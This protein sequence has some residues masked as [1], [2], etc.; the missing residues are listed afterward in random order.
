MSFLL[1]QAQTTSSTKKTV[2]E[3]F[4]DTL[5]EMSASYFA[6]HRMWDDLDIPTPRVKLKADYHKL[7]VPPTYYFAPVQQAFEL[8][9][10]PSDK[11]GM[12]AVDSLN[13]VIK[14]AEPQYELPK[15]TNSVGA[16]RWV[17]EI[18]L[19]VYLN[20]PN[21]VKGNEASFADMK[22]L[23]DAHTIVTPRKENLV[24]YVMPGNEKT[25]A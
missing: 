1:V 7:I 14:S 6:Y 16:D 18:L 5:Q 23:S 17:N 8:D 22:V 3:A 2:L 10:E 13:M 20:Y 11:M 9:W 12:D 25:N 24:S 21:I 19:N 15:L 4:T